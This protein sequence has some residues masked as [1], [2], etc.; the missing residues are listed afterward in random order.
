MRYIQSGML[1]VLTFQPNKIYNKNEC[2]HNSLSQ[3]VQSDGVCLKFCRPSVFTLQ[4]L[5]LHFDFVFCS[6]LF[7]LDQHDPTRPEMTCSSFKN[8]VHF[9]KKQEREV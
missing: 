6:D 2:S 8:S 1:Q 3:E 4:A 5:M 9:C 7:L